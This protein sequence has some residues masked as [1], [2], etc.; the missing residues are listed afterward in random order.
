M[1][2][3]FIAVK[4][5]TKSY[6]MPYG[7]IQPLK[8]ATFSIERQDFVA[9]MGPSG[10]GKSSLL[11]LLGC[12]D[13]PSEGSYFFQG[14]NVASLEDKDL[15]KLRSKEIGFIFQDFHLIPELTVWENVLLP[16]S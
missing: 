2:S 4:N 1:K 10:S 6:N 16:F 12:L 13:R 5:L 3:P 9:I 14:V 11:Y 8:D 7:I 15:S